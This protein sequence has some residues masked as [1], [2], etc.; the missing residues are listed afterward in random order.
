M[1]AAPRAT[2]RS[3]ASP[4]TTGACSSWYSAPTATSYTRAGGD[5]ADARRHRLA[6]GRRR[7]PAPLLPGAQV[8]ISDR[9][10]K[11]IAPC[12]KAPA[13]RSTPIRTTT[14]RTHG[15]DFD[16]DDGGAAAGAPAGAIVVL[17]ACCHN[18]TGADLTDEQ[19]ERVIEIVRTRGQMPFLDLAYQG[20]ADGIDADGASSSPVRRDAGAVVRRQ[21]VFE[22]RSRST[23]SGSARCPSSA[24][25][26]DE[27]ARVLSQIKRVVRAQLF[28]PADLRR[29]DRRDRAGLAG[30]AR[31]VGA[32]ARGMRTASRRCRRALV[33]ALEQA[34]CPDRDFSFMLEQRGMF[35]YSGLTAEQVLATA[36]RIFGLRDQHRPDLRCG[37]Q[38]PQHRLRRG[39]DC[40]RC[41]A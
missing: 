16:G 21:L 25:D 30:A 22:D 36:Q 26:R 20:F 24:A 27:A 38:L 11:I 7:F 33:E 4:P 12:S 34:R 23:A 5:R 35:S 14:R 15:V 1:R 13:S 32:R 6:Q 39:R 10:G 3:T 19:W 9:P 17:H 37:A 40:R 18:P 29:P 2:C 8:W 31:E 41:M 28:E